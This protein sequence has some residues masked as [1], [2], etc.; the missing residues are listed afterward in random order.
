[1]GEMADPTPPTAPGEK[2]QRARET[3]CSDL[4][5]EWSGSPGPG[6]LRLFSG[7]GPKTVPWEEGEEES[8]RERCWGQA[9]VKSQ[10]QKGRDH[11]HMP[12]YV[13]FFESFTLLKHDSIRYPW[14]WPIQIGGGGIWGKHS[15]I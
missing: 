13:N 7:P 15:V 6:L 5:V 14:V 8:Q 4:R 11:T 3:V 1:M 2:E 9:L 12:G 10:N